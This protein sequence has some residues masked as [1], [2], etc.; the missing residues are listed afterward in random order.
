MDAIVK[1]A[2]AKNPRHRFETMAAFRAALLDP[3]AYMASRPTAVVD[4]ASERLAVGRVTRIETLGST[5]R[6]TVSERTTSSVRRPRRRMS[7]GLGAV[8]VLALGVVLG[9]RVG[10]SG[11]L[12]TPVAAESAP[13]AE[14]TVTQTEG[15]RPTVAGVAKVEGELPLLTSASATPRST[16]APVGHRHHHKAVID[17]PDG[18]LALS[19]P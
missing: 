17:D 15:E 19:E 14:T 18:I 3:E 5:G 11:P 8:A 7:V 10:T 16:S 1:R 2:M 9:L 6:R 13:R 4:D 12:P